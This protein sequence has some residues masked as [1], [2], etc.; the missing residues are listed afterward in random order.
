MKAQEK[1]HFQCL[2]CGQLIDN[3]DDDLRQC[4]K[5]NGPISIQ[6]NIEQLKEVI[7]KEK[8]Y[9]QQIK[10]MWSFFEFLPLLNKK[11]SFH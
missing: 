2:K 8:F 5:C 9:A 7:S 11:I 1:Y 4:L 10:S 3:A 6:M